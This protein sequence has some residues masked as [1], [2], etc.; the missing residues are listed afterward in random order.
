MFI[1][2]VDNNNSEERYES[3]KTSNPSSDK[4]TF[5]V[6]GT[7]AYIDHNGET[8][9]IWYQADVH[10]N[11]SKSAADGRKFVRVIKKEG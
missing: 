8:K 5:T 1:F 11:Q 3:K 4:E 10:F 9:T 6:E 2:S 7:L